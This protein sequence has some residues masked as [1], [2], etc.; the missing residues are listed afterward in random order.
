MSPNTHEVDISA[1][2]DYGLSSLKVPDSN[3]SGNPPPRRTWTTVE[4]AVVFN[5][6]GTMKTVTRER[7]MTRDE[8]AWIKRYH[9][10]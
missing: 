9:P 10:D 8:I 2:I 4:R 5:P 3:D 6:D 1:F 7:A